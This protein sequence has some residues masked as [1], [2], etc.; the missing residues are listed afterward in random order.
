MVYR[1][2]HWAEAYF[3]LKIIRDCQLQRHISL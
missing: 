2:Y 1:S 3:W